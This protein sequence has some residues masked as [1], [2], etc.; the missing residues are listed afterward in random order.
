MACTARF[1][2]T[3]T[4]LSNLTR[5]NIKNNNG[6]SLPSSPKIKRRSRSSDAGLRRK[7]TQK[8]PSVAQVER[9]IG[10]GI[11]RDRNPSGDEIPTGFDFLASTPIGQPEG[12]P[13]KKLREAGEWILNR[14][15][16]GSRSGQEILMVVCLNI[17]PLWLFFLLVASGIIKLPFSLPYLDDLLM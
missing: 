9:A 15:E 16:G 4:I 17:L 11:F 10:A 5:N 3:I 1:S 6:S 2:A 8:K 7:P 12:S 13:E 14:T